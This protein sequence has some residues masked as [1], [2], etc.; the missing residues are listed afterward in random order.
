MPWA[1]VAG[2][3]FSEF[4]SALQFRDIVLVCSGAAI[5]PVLGLSQYFDPSVHRVT[6]IWLSRDAELISFLLPICNPATKIIVHYTGKTNAKEKIAALKTQKF[7]A[8]PSLSTKQQ[9]KVQ[10]QRAAQEQTVHN[11]AE[12]L[13]VV[14]GRPKDWDTLLDEHIAPNMRGETC[15]CIS[16]GVKR[17][18][19]EVEQL[20]LKKGIPRI[21]SDASF[22]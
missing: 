14:F 7:F 19:S 2:P 4:Q 18:A 21:R 15:V 22:G 3:L 13:E 12:K 11:R 8:A 9:M 10:Q 20:C 17:L 16:S 5:T 1:W 6:L